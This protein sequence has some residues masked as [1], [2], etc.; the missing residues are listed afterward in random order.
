[1]IMHKSF[2][3]D[4][5]TTNST[6]SVVKEGKVIYAEEKPAKNKTIPSIIAIRKNASEVCGSLAKNEFYTG[7]ENSIKSIKREMGKKVDFKVGDNDYSPEMISSKIIAYC[8]ECLIDTI[9]KEDN[10]V[11]D[12][13]V[14]TVPAYFNLAQKDATRKAGELAGLNV[15]M[16]LEEPTA[17]AINFVVSNNIENGLFFVFD[18]GGGTFDVSILEKIENIPTVLA[19]AGNN[20][21]GGDNFDFILARYFLDVLREQ[22]HSLKD[23]TASA[24][25]KKFRLLMFAAE[26]VKKQLSINESYNIYF[27]D[28]FKD[29]TGVEL[30]IDDFTRTKFNDLIKDKVEKDIIKECDKALKLLEENHDKKLEDITHILMVGGSTK[31]PYI[32][33]IVKEKYCVTN[34]LKELTF[35]EPDLSV[36]AGAAFVANTNGYSIEDEKNCLN[37]DM[38]AAYVINDELYITGQ[39]ISGNIDRI[40]IKIN[41][42]E[43]NA[44]LSEDKMFTI[45]IPK[46][47]YNNQEIKFYNKDVCINS[48]N[49]E[50]N[51]DVDIIAPTPIQNE[52]IAVTIIDVEKGKTEQYPIVFEGSYLP[53]EVTETFKINE[54]SNKQIILPIWEGSRKIFNFIID[55]PK[56]SKIGDK[57]SV[58]TFVDTISNVTLDVRM[59][60]KKLDGSYEYITQ[61][62]IDNEETENLD[63]LFDERIKCVEDF[64]LKEKL[65]TQREDIVRELEEAKSN[66]DET[67]YANVNQKY[68]KAVS[69]MPISQALTEE[70]FDE[71][72]TYIKE[73]NISESKFTNY[74][75]DNQCFYGKRYLR[76]ENILEAEKCMDA[77]LSMKDSIDL[78]GSPNKYFNQIKSIVSVV[79]AMAITYIDDPTANPSIKHAIN[80]EINLNYPEIDK[81]MKKYNEDDN[82]PEMINDADKLVGLTARL[83]Q[84]IQSELPEGTTNNS[85][86]NGLVSKA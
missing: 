62:S 37:V 79:L 50:D 43:V 7:N 56:D 34:N 14:I 66:N 75:V 80:N 28:I 47:D 41:N 60:E 46:K 13:V 65:I 26:N 1:M 81:L 5:G 57:I 42:Q 54:F 20:F 29:N 55:L 18:L 85:L 2:G 51:G 58:T 31:I 64:E 8:K 63:E 25:D 32:Q 12:K 17:A 69:E 16:L 61:E 77:L 78:L 10:V 40:S 27:P 44:E 24:E 73:K 15:Q 36:S 74:D 38:N 33:N 6:A 84:L 21:L 72:A 23:I 4:L 22:G 30:L 39:I 67:H 82:D 83:Y 3:L 45:I 48:I 71:V 53:S 52:T 9:G 49:T 11:Y 35:Y 86:F 76:K 68:E 19:T 70:K 59:N